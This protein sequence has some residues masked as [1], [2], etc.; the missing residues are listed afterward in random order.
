MLPGVI[1]AIDGDAVAVRIYAG[2][3]YSC[4]LENYPLHLALAVDVRLL[5]LGRHADPH[6]TRIVAAGLLETGDADLAAAVRARGSRGR[7][8]EIAEA[9]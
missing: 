3:E 7:V 5:D 1:E 6:L 2:P 8:R 9:A 4:T